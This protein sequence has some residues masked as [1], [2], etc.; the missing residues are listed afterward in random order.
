MEQGKNNDMQKKTIAV[1]LLVIVLMVLSGIILFLVGRHISNIREQEQ[2]QL[3]AGEFADIVAWQD[4]EAL[5]AQTRFDKYLY[6]DVRLMTGFLKEYVTE[7]GYSGPRVFEDG[8]VA[9]LKGEN[10]VIPDGAPGGDMQI[11][12]ELVEKSLASGS[13]RT[14]SFSYN[15][16]NAESAGKLGESIETEGYYLSFG[17]ITDD[18]VYVLLTEKKQFTD[19]LNVYS[20]GRLVDTNTITDIFGGITLVAADENGT[21]ELLEKYGTE[22]DSVNPAS[23]GITSEMAG[24]GNIPNIQLGKQEYRVVCVKTVFKQKDRENVYMIQLLPVRNTS[25]WVLLQAVLTSLLML[26]LLIT[27]IVYAV[28]EQRLVVEG[29][30]TAENAGRYNPKRLRHRLVSAGIAGALTVLLLSSLTQAVVQMHQQIRHGRDVM[31]ILS[32]QLDESSNTQNDEMK[33]AEEKWYVHFSQRIASILENNPK[34]AV[35][36]KLLECRNILNVDYIMLFDSAGDEIISSNDYTGFSLDLDTGE[37]FLDFHRLLM[38]VPTVVHDAE[39]GDVTE[40]ERQIIGVKMKALDDPEKHGAL[41]MA[42]MP[43]QTFVITDAEGIQQEMTLLSTGE[44]LCFK[45]DTSTGIIDTSS[46]RSLT[47]KTV[48]EC[49]LTEKS[50][51][52]NYMD[53]GKINGTEYF[54]V[55]QRHNDRIFYYADACDGQ[56]KNILQ[57]AFSAMI[58]FVLALIIIS[59]F[60]MKGYDA[61]FYNEW[62][63]KTFEKQKP[64]HED[65]AATESKPGLK[66][67]VSKLSDYQKEAVEKGDMFLQSLREYVQWGSKLPEEKAG[68]VFGIGLCLLLV[69]LQVS[70]VLG[71]QDVY[72]SYDSLLGYLLHGDWMRGINLFSLCG[73]ALTMSVIHLFNSMTGWIL[74]VLSGF[75]S[76]KG[77]TICKLMRSLI[78]YGSVAVALVLSLYYVGVLN[79]TVIASLGLGSLAISLGAKDLISDILAGIFIVFDETLRVGDFVEYEG[80]TGTVVEIGMRYTKLLIPV[81]N[82]LNVGNQEIR[83]VMNLSKSISG[84]NLDIYVLES[85]PLPRIEELFRRELPALAAKC[86][87]IHG[88]IDYQGVVQLG[89]P[90]NYLVTISLKTLRIAVQCEQRDLYDVQLFMNREICLL[91]EREGIQYY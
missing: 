75:L 56:L 71:G 31:D 72:G 79:S 32:E 42:L 51:Q 52:D 5:A 54:I 20:T 58:L 21:L 11:S 78:R 16:I 65:A 1:F 12:R 87:K 19:Y 77:N 41:L 45:A 37:K 76:V 59:V 57:F 62:A 84:Y 82:I 86:D 50:L 89:H 17:R 61:P 81:G 2:E 64:V 6:Q 28:S 38:G 23:L 49:G 39:T 27:L 85:E 68:T 3:K 91:L 34:L 22:D 33:Q 18:F 83:T 14:G 69:L 9:E 48:Q 4:R 88:P 90:D 74:Q 35:Q 25:H 63:K 8:F 73:I 53:F 44:I 70:L 40:L 66:K 47:G 60:L 29:G 36:E 10:A 80:K 24:E 7:D 13:M 46:K 55:T 67:A 26:L 43:D 15:N 30:L